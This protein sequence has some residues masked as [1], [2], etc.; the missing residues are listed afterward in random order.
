MRMPKK[1]VKSRWRIAPYSEAEMKYDI[2][3]AGHKRIIVD[4]AQMAV[5]SRQFFQ[6]LSE[7]LNT[8]YIIQKLACLIYDT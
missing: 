3:E 1:E 8:W 5:L 4:L 7:V 2:V 6:T